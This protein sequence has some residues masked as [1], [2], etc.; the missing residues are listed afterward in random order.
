MNGNSRTGCTVGAYIR[1]EALLG[2]NRSEQ[3]KW[4][5]KMLMSLGYARVALAKFL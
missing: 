4:L 2:T 3:Q 5:R 1:H